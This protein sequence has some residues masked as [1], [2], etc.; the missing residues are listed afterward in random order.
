M[1]TREDRALSYKM[2]AKHDL[3][4]C[5]SDLAEVGASP[6]GGV[7]RLALSPEEAELHR[8]VASWLEELGGQIRR[9]AIGNLIARFE[10]SD[11]SLPAVAFGSHLDSVPGGGIYDGVVGVVAGIAAV[12]AIREMGIVTRHPLE[13]IAFVGEESSRF[14]VATLGSKIMCGLKNEKYLLGLRDA[15]G[16]TLK[17]AALKQGADIGN[18]ASARRRPEELKAFIELHIEQGRVLEETRKKIG[19]VNAI[20]APTRWF[21]EIEGRAD[22][23]GATP[24]N[25]RFDALPAAAE[26]ILAVERQGRKEAVNKT[27]ATIGT[28]SIKPG[29]MNVIPGHVGLGLDVRGI[30][31]ESVRRTIDGIRRELEEISRRRKVRFRMHELSDE[32]PLV[33]DAEMVRTLQKVCENRGITYTIMPSG[34][35]HDAMNMARLTPSGLIFIPCRNGVSHSPLEQADLDDIALGA[36]VLLGAVLELAGVESNTDVRGNQAWTNSSNG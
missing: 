35:G 17:E 9:D 12:K 10:G 6:E 26:L 30:E 1:T 25:L 33:L 27:V 11:N 32:D 21:I 13:V 19:I 18:L 20:A 5:I 24:M 7:T 2:I 23:S 36:E 4:R 3:D 16:V 34:A 31:K 28:A 15:E 14:G 8:R 29:A 22:H